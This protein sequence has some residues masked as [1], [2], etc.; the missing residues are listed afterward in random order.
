MST[1][2]SK[3]ST[4][5]AESESNARRPF[6]MSARKARRREV[7]QTYWAQEQGQAE[8]GLDL[9]ARMNL[10]AQYGDF[11]LAY[12]T[13]VQPR[14]MHFGDE[15]GYIAYRKRWAM[16][17]ALGDVVASES[18]RPG[19]LDEF[20][21]AHQRVSFCQ[22]SYAVA[23]LL[24]DRGFLINEMGVDTTLDLP[25]YT[26]C[27]KEKEWL[28]YASNWT[29]KRNYQI[30]EAGFDSIDPKQVESVSE[31]WRK[32]RTV[33]RKE[34]RFLN[35][36][37]VL[38]EE[39]D[40]RKFFLIS[41]TGELQAFVFLDPI[42]RDAKIPGYVTVIKRRHPDAPLYAEQAIMKSI[43]EKLKHEGVAELKLG[44]SPFA[45]IED[46]DFRSNRMTG[47]LFQR[48]YRANWVNRHCYNVAGH[49][50]YKRR[51]RGREQK[52]YFASPTRFN[53]PRMAALIGLCGIA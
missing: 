44:L 25:D 36:P 10:I 11:S 20:L 19:L 23:R 35:R 3:R 1:L 21:K 53:T 17:F 8:T 15:N 43:I 40:V 50:Q 13:A 6:Y 18:R 38:K 32:T 14:V 39:P 31:A 48:A 7:S 2:D 29:A 26:F 47:W 27:G 5:T 46:N 4:E 34:V 49:A 9:A 45:E 28:R 12:S 22:V 30:V 52:V 51:F 33:K 24:A 42:Y 16:T 41:P 37:I